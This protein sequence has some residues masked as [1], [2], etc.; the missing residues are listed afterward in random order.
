[1]RLLAVALAAVALVGSVP[2]RRT[3]RTGPAIFHGTLVDPS[4]WTFYASMTHR[5]QADKARRSI[6]CGAAVVAPTT[7][8]TASHC[9]EGEGA[10]L[11]VAVGTGLNPHV[12]GEVI[13][14]RR[15]V[16]APDADPATFSHDVA[17]LELDHA[18]PSSVAPVPVATPADDATLL[19]GGDRVEV[20]G[21][22][23][24]D[25]VDPSTVAATELRSAAMEVTPASSCKVE[26]EN[27]SRAVMNDD[28]FC[29]NGV[30]G[31]D[32][33]TDD[34]GDPCYG[35]SGG[36]IVS[37]RGGAPV[38]VGLVSTGTAQ[39]AT[40]SDIQPRLSAFATFLKPY[41]PDPPAH[42]AT[43]APDPPAAAP[44]A[45]SSVTSGRA[46]H[47]VWST[48]WVLFAA[49]VLAAALAA[50]LVFGYRHR[51]RGSGPSEPS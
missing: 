31:T 47:T 28:E 29:T 23:Q 32:R 37:R 26:I 46:G 40:G 39:C 25:N 43:H 27:G 15:V 34:V 8:L 18:V 2:L 12:G 6:F 35:D 51:R 24:T 17:V 48:A 13:G 49:L 7:V 14:V 50:R 4:S 10:N 38:L 42:A 41:L 30:P 21:V 11:A 9:A 19:A 1:V 45:R 20:A 44:R 33:H 5:D 3:A 22:G 16:L 36:P